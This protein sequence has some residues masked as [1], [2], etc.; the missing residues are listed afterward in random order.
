MPHRSSVV[1]T[2]AS[3]GVGR[4]TARAFAAKGWNV[5]L[6]ARGKAGLEGAAR[7]VRRAGGMPLVIPTDVAQAEQVFAAAQQV[8]DAWGQIDVW[9][10]NAMVTVFAPVDQMTSEE[11]ARVTHVTYLGQV[12]GT[13]AALRHMRKTGSGTIVQIGSA[14]SYRA[15]PLQSAYCGAKA[16]ARVFTDALRSELLHDG[17]RIRVTAVHLPAVNTPQFDWGRTKMNGPPQPVPP[18]HTPQ[19]IARAIVKAA[20]DC[21][22]EV[23]VGWPTL[24]TILGNLVAPGLMDRLMADRAYDSQVGPGE[25]DAERP[26]NL[27]EP[28]DRDMGAQGRF[29][30]RSSDKAMAFPGPAVRAGVIL[31]GIGA[32]AGLTLLLAASAI[33]ERR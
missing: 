21:P 30:D 25:R 14:L 10:N 2:G 23:W 22:R 6:L 16:A 15:I 3:A 17:S 31:A 11:F 8:V 1:I 33:R 9:I 12:H 13:M 7:D 5:A 18:I 29:A 20:H 19:V 28:V 27:F 32:T 24:Q 4:A 26:D